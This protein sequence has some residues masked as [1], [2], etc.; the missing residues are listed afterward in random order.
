VGTSLDGIVHTLPFL[1]PVWVCSVV[2]VHFFP[3]S[4]TL[5]PQVS[6]RRTGRH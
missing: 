5:R 1:I 6:A 2:A 4:S 3:L